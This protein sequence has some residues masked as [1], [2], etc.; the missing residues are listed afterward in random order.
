MSTA[1]MYDVGSMAAII[2]SATV[3]QSK[4]IIMYFR[5]KRSAS[6]PPSSAA[7]SDS[8]VA[9]AMST[10]AVPSERPSFVVRKNVSMG[11]TNEPIAVT[12]FP[13]NRM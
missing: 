12:S 7:G 10:V 5:L 11:Q 4:M 8:T 6:F 1:V 3:R 13:T 9:V 2:Y